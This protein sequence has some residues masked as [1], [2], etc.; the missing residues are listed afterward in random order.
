MAKKDQSRA[1][2]MYV[3]D[4]LSSKRIE[5]MDANEERGYL[6]LLLN[7]WTSP[8]CGL[9]DSDAELAIMSK[10]G[11]LWNKPTKDK[12]K[13]IPGLTSGQK[14]RQCFGEIEGRLYNERQLREWQYQQDAKKKRSESGSKGNTKRWGSDALE[15]SPS[16]RIAIANESQSDR[17][18][19]ANAS[20]NDRNIVSVSVSDSVIDCSLKKQVP[21]PE[22]EVAL[23]VVDNRARLEEIFGIFIA[24]GKGVSFSDQTFCTNRWD[25]YTLAQ[26]IKAHRCAVESLPE[27]QSRETHLI[28]M[29][30]NWF[31]E[32]QWERHTPRLIPQT[33]P[34]SKT[35]TNHEQAAAEFIAEQKAAGR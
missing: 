8:D 15:S 30:K 9:P 7:A 10:L 17:K 33:A 28:P 18:P 29:P 20:Q 4:W 24:L 3:D 14:L 26:Q 35:Q 1:F 32:N 23:A 27:W 11:P 16:D 21:N 6:R 25:G 12:D 2:F 34:K 5:M 13:R 22:A 31:R 19:I